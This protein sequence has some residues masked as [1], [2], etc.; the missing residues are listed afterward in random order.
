[1]VIHDD[2]LVQFGEVLGFLSLLLE[3]LILFPP[4]GKK[5][6]EV[7]FPPADSLPAYMGFALFHY[8][9]SEEAGPCLLATYLYPHQ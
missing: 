9:C 7:H 8:M 4:A 1:M 6:G 3:T 2:F 5:K